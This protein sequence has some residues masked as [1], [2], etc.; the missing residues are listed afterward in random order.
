MDAEKKTKNEKAAGDGAGQERPGSQ[1]M[2]SNQ[3][4]TV[5]AIQKEVADLV[6]TERA[7][8]LPRPLESPEFT[9]DEALKAVKEGEDGDAWIF[10]QKMRGKRVFDHAAGRWYLF[11][12]HWWTEDPVE[13]ILAD[14]DCVIQAYLMEAS[15]WFSKRFEAEQD[16]DEE[17]A[18]EAK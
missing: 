15:Y 5:A 6:E 17:A 12:D 3:T 10:I 14:L 16:K 13:Q 8:F 18:K 4:A 11:R 2:N 9:H 1:V 7:A